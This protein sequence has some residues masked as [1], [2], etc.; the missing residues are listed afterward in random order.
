[1]ICYLD[2]S[3]TPILRT[4]KPDFG[5]GLDVFC[6]PRSLHHLICKNTLLSKFSDTFEP[7]NK[8]I[9]HLLALETMVLLSPYLGHCYHRKGVFHEEDEGAIC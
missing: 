8:K 6:E 1:M 4:L 3:T 5:K 9:G 7:Q 2:K